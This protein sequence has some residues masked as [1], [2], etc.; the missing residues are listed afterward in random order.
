MLIRLEG[1]ES[2]NDLI[3]IIF[4]VYTPSVQD[5]R[6][7]Y[8]EERVEAMPKA[9]NK[10]EGALNKISARRNAQMVSPFYINL[11]KY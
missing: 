8:S 6:S 11:Y 5:T 7:T 2:S 10:K 1:D 3:C 9:I 4:Y